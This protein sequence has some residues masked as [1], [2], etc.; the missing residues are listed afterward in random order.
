[1]GGGGNRVEVRVKEI[2]EKTEGILAGLGVPAQD[3]AL[4]ADILLDAERRG[5]ESHGLMR[6]MTYADRIRLG[7]VEAD[8]RIEV[9]VNGAVARVDGGNGLGQVVM[10][11]AAEAGVGLA[12]EYG[13]GMAAVCHSNHFAAAG[14]YAEMIAKEGCIGIVASAAAPTMAPCGG[15]DVF[16]GTDPIAVAFPGA[17]QVFYGDIA[18]SASSRG[19]IRVCSKTGQDIPAGWALDREGNDTTDAKKALD[20]ILLPMNGHKGYIL[21]MA[22]E[23]ASCLLSGANLSCESTS[24][25]DYTR[26]TNTGHSLIAID[27]AHFLPLDEFRERAQKWFDLIKAGTPRP[28]HEIRIPGERGDARKRASAETLSILRE[29]ADAIDALAVTLAP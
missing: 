20:G 4:V 16:F 22:V 28:G 27:I 8:P 21:A 29:T 12:R 19:K 14:Y 7:L 25:F 15:M 17:E 24:I 2:R 9:S 1:M 3:A 18:T 5:V 10:A 11:R 6:L 23:A 13:I 26:T